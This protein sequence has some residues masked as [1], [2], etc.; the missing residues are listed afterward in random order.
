MLWPVGG[1][2]HV[3]DVM[4]LL[5]RFSVLRL[6]EEMYLRSMRKEHRKEYVRMYILVSFSPCIWTLYID[7]LFQS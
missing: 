5:R 6:L 4:T 7:S 3:V 1:L 2:V